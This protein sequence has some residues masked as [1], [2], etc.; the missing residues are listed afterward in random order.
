MV[1]CMQEIKFYSAH[2]M[3]QA[4]LLNNWKS[5]A[6]PV[7]P[8][9]IGQRP[10]G[11]FVPATEGQ[12][13]LWLLQQLY[14]ENLFYQY[15]H[16]YDFTGPLRV[17]LLEQSFQQLIDRREILRTN[18]I[19]TEQGL[20]LRV[21]PKINVC[22][23]KI[24]STGEHQQ[25]TANNGTDFATLKFSQ[26]PF[27]LAEGPL[28]RV[29]LI[30][31][32][33]YRHRLLFSLH[34]AIGDRGS[35]QL[36]EKELFTIYAALVAGTSPKL[37]ELSIQFPDFAYWKAKQPRSEKQLTYW[38]DYLAG[39]VPQPDLSPDFKRPAHPSFRG[40]LI[41]TTLSEAVSAGIDQ[42]AKAY[43]TT[44]NVVLLAAF[45]LLQRRYSGADEVWVGSPV[46]IRKRPEEQQLVGFLN[47]TLVF[48]A[49][50]EA[51]D[52][53][54]DLV[55]RLKPA[56]E[57]ALTEHDVSFE[58]LV[59]RLNPPRAGG[60]NPLFQTMFVYN[61]EATKHELP[62]GLTMTD[63]MVDLG[64]AKFDLT[65]FATKRAAVYDLSLEF[66]K[67]LFT[68][69]TA[70]A[71]LGHLESL[72]TGILASPDRPV[73]KLPLLSPTEQRQLHDQWNATGGVEQPELLPHRIVA[74]AKVNGTA[75]AVTDGKHQLTY[76][77]L[78][79]KA[80]KVA[81]Q[82]AETPQPMIGLYGHRHPDTLA[83]MLGI[84]L[85]GGAYLPLDPAYPAE[86]INLMLEDAGVTTIVDQTGEAKQALGGNYQYMA[87][88]DAETTGVS[89]EFPELTPDHL[90]YIIYTSGSTGRPKGV[91][92]SHGNL[93]FSTVA[94]NQF[95]N[96][97]PSCF[98]LMSSFSFDSSVAGIFWT[99]AAGGKLLLS[100]DRAEQDPAVLAELIRANGVTH[101]LLL[102]SLYQLLLEYANPSDLAGLQT[103]MVAGEACS[104]ALVKRH[105]AILPGTQLVNEYG[106]TEGT[107]WSTAHCITPA[108]ALGAVPIGKPIPGVKHYIVDEN[109]Q[110]LPAGYPGELLIS[111][112]GLTAGYYQRPELTQQRFAPNPFS[113]EPGYERFY[114]TGDLVSYRR[115][116]EGVIDFLGRR[117]QQL[118]IRG[119][120]IELDE[121][122]RVLEE[123]PGIREAV[124]RPFTTP[125][126]D[127]LQL[128]GYFTVTN[129]FTGTAAVKDK[130]TNR[131]PGYMVPAILQEL[132]EIPRL[133]NGK[134]NLNSLPL[135]EQ[136]TATTAARVAH[137]PPVTTLEIQL[138]GIWEK[139]LGYAPVGRTDNFFA[140]GGDSLKSIR[141]IGEARKL[142]LK[143]QP[144]HLFVYQTIAELAKALEEVAVVNREDAEYRAVVPLK[145][146]GNKPPLFCLHSGGGHVFFYQPL[147]AH[148]A[149]D[150][151]LY[152]IQPKGLGGID[153][154]HFQSIEEMA[155]YYLA[156]M[157][158]VQPR[159]PYHLLGTC[160][161][162]AVGLEIA[163]QL[164]RAGEEIATLIFVDSGPAHLQSQLDETK[165][166]QPV[167][168]F[169]RK[170]AAGDWNYLTRKLKNKLIIAGWMISSA[171]N[172]EKRDTY[173]TIL[174]LNHL[175]SAYNWHPID[176]QI[177]FIRSSQFVQL[178]EKN[179]H[180]AQW[181]KLAGAG[182][183][184]HQ[185]NGHHVTLFQEPEV[186]GLAE[187]INKVLN[188]TTA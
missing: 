48:R 8:A 59:D 46:S 100:P 12:R 127:Q 34:H 13:R 133:P 156:E 22:L 113:S 62:A 85:A 174:G 56:V 77:E 186:A 170:L 107:V 121:I 33:E 183:R 6:K 42:T 19:D 110:L 172:Q 63:Q 82:L 164:R 122:A 74:T 73:T 128:V 116:T 41:T 104:P 71:T 65:L 66:A 38:L 131:L 139:V 18:L 79:A 35:L 187:A 91:P 27:N 78:L 165:A 14:P 125:Q 47:E 28:F 84:L 4:D 138:A 9:P 143:L 166:N 124:V 145:T 188:L 45:Q 92:I 154:G 51:N 136:S 147:S 179:L 103:V 132:D 89:L 10:E 86:R 44:P 123:I 117:D 141:V 70:R 181:N 109:D 69:D 120:R 54:G 90:A 129:G 39:S 75:T 31:I 176:V 102:P 135:P 155:A 37:P 111:G 162:N 24:S 93:A 99:L 68:A 61:A 29:G 173:T 49:S 3:N 178:P 108:D 21:Q 105:F 161:S 180:L 118:K 2:S 163:H 106:P 26:Q 76:A 142:E 40:G 134:I 144:H 95:F 58:E 32:S 52:T 97:S 160:F 83:G 15:T 81:Q 152:A 1:L 112:P 177:D 185:V 140:A 16:Q 87:V 11:A 72:L 168:N 157:R 64:T 114:R 169:F 159:G 67:D 146:S 130:L 30:K 88:T 149:A 96:R 184:V 53:F 167:R 23:T 182:L 137:V 171:N 50:F 5:R 20:E 7:A 98:L 60:W 151:P 158:K 175:Y 17:E 25:N 36:L 119:Y 148:L 115:G 94:R 126:N 55:K 43:Q 80:A 153:E 150:R 101:T 57:R